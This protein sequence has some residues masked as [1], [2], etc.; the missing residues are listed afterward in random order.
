MATKRKL[1]APA[2]DTP[3][4]QSVP[5][6]DTAAGPGD[7]GQPA[8]GTGASSPPR[9]EPGEEPPQ[10]W[11]KRAS[12]IVDPDA[13]VKF[14][15]DYENHKAVITFNEKPSPELLAMLR[16]LLN[17]GRFQWDA[18]NNDGWKKTIRF[19]QRE[20]DRRE[21]KKTFYAVADAIRE[22]KGLPV[23]SF[24]EHEPPPF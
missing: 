10:S 21:A 18:V 16:P 14:H 1:A 19:I 7:G 8:P 15:F 22:H 11:V 5:Q 12:I 4:Q 6:T 17:E 24:G 23:R 9:R 3:A 2:E 20:D 13:G